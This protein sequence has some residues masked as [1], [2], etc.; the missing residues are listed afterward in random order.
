MN[1]HALVSGVIGAINPNQAISIQVSAGYTIAPDRKQVPA[2]ERA[3]TL[4]AQVQQL[5]TQDL[6][7]LE[8][9]GIQGSTRKIWMN[10][11]VEAI[12]RVSEK[13]GDLITLRDG[14]I[15]L[16]T[17]VMERWPD[18]CSVSVTLQNGS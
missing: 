10:G 11:S 16:T 14:T 2:Y 3:F 1:L 9:M 8:S 17:A 5:S 7:K 15:W 18:W 13:G 12:M 4:I 6:R